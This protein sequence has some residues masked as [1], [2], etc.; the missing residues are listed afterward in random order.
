[1]G[2][3][4]AIL[5]AAGVGSRI[6]A[7]T[8]KPKSTLAVSDDNDTIIAHTLRMLQSNDFKI[9][10]IVGYR[11]DSVKAQLEGYEVNYFENPYYRITNS[12]ASLWFAKDALIEAMENGQEVILG[13]ADVFWGTELLEKILSDEHDCTM[14]ADSHRVEVGDYFFNV[15]DNGILVANGKQLALEDRNCEYV[16]IAKIS[17]AFL[18]TFIEHLDK[19]IWNEDYNMW[20]EDV[21]YSFKNESPVHVLDVEGRFWGEV[22]TLEDYQRIVDYIAEHPE[23]LK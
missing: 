21:L 12:I 10:L 16:G 9:N 13:N 3:Y 11:K 19:L 1:M 22:D 18:P 2:K 20:W 6:S 23:E 15:D 5:M 4:Q 17:S 14:L 7:H 8:N